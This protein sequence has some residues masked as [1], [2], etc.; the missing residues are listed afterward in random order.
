MADQLCNGCRFWQ[1]HIHMGVCKRYPSI[2]NKSESDWCGE[3]S[4][5]FM[6]EPVPEPIPEPVVIAEPKKR[7]RPRK[8]AA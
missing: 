8:E 1:K 5:K 7:G 3:W 6:P 2:C 4:A